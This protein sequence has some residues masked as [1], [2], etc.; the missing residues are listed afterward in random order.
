MMNAH[1]EVTSRLLASLAALPETEQA[2]AMQAAIG[3]AIKQVSIYQI[4][5]LRQR[6]R[7]DFDVGNP[8]IRVITDMIDGQIALR[9]IAGTASWR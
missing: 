5:E 1:D 8:A 2:E 6:I 4:L 9:E 3:Q 7:G